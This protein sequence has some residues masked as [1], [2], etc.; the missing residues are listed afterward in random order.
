MKKILLPVLIIFTLVLMNCDNV[1]DDINYTITNSSSK[2]IAFSFN[3]NDYNLNSN[4][5]MSL[6]INSDEGEFYPRNVAPYN[7]H[8]KSVIIETEYLGIN[9]GLHK[10]SYI[11]KD[12]I[13]YNLKITNSL[14]V[15]VTI[16]SD[17]NIDNNGELTI[18]INP[19][20]NKDSYIYTS[21][22]N[23]TLVSEP[24]PV[25]FDWTFSN[26]TVYVVIR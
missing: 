10:K 12:N 1:F 18:T 26:N 5:S 17:D 25:I 19:N 23:F 24:Y 14:Q 11:F 8:S 9:N 22:P 2:L 7:A 3:N 20:D 4:D 16:K 13:R 6:T 15:Q 21:N